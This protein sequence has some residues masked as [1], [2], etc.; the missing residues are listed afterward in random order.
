MNV[1]LDDADLRPGV[2][3]QC[4]HGL[5]H[6]RVTC[7]NGLAMCLGQQVLRVALQSSCPGLCS[8]P[9]GYC[10]WYSC[11][12]SPQKGEQPSL[13]PSLRLLSAFESNLHEDAPPMS[14]SPVAEL[15]EDV[16]GSVTMSS[17]TSPKPPWLSLVSPDDTTDA[18][19]T[20]RRTLECFGRTHSPRIVC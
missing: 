13:A 12:S 11:H 2:W 7:S 4:C 14:C 20:Q 3:R 6:P 9:P 5:A 18:M 10:S 8:L 15:G 16:Q 19:L 1:G 17:Q